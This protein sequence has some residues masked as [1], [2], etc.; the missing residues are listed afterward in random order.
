LYLFGANILAFA[1]IFVHFRSSV[2]GQDVVLLLLY[3]TSTAAQHQQQHNRYITANWP[4]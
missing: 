4:T 2:V 1:F 3:S